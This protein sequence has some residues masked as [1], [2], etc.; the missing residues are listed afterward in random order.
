M[1]HIIF[2][3]GGQ[4]SG[5]SRFAMEKAENESEN[6]VYL[7]TSR[8]WDPEH[9][10]RIKQHQ[11]DRKAHWETIENEKEISQHDFTG[12]TVLMDCFN[13][14]M[15]NYFYDLD[16]D[17]D[18]SLEEG[19]KHIEA[20]NKQDF[21]WIIVT[22]EIGMGGHPVSRMQSKFTDLLGWMNQYIASLAD[23]AY[24]MVSGL[25]VKIK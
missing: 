16:Q 17:I 22:N 15:T 25:P 8:F 7:A 20:L 5:K 12:R 14:S 3:T 23:E 18:Q 11:L 4:R 9:A 10:Q 13:I 2:I 19:K 1:A 6:P 24:L 21:L